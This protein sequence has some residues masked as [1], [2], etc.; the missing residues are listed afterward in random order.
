M[1]SERL[2]TL[3]R[4]PDCRAQLERR[5][6]RPGRLVCGSCR[7]EFTATESYLDM[8]PGLAFAEQT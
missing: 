1:I 2:L 5:P 6:A 8:R 4:C 7:R 3:V